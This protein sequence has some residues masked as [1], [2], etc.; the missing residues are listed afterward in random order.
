M[1]RIVEKPNRVKH[2]SARVG[3]LYSL[4]GPGDN[5]R[6]CVTTAQKPGAS[7]RS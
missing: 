3:S 2:K 5:E 4:W 1:I 6:S 7:R